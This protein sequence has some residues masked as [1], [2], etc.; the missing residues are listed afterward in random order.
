[1]R[2]VLAFLAVVTVLACL[3]LLAFAQEP[4]P[5][6]QAP[7]E[8]PVPPPPPPPPKP[9]QP[10]KPDEPKEP[11][12]SPPDQEKINEAVKKGVN[13]LAKLQQKDG[14]FKVYYGTSY[15][16][17]CS[18]LALL[19][20]LKSGVNPGS[21]AI[22][23]GFDYLEDLPL[24]RMY[25]VAIYVLALEAL[26]A[27]SEKQLDRKGKPYIT[28]LRENIRRRAP[29]EDKSKV[30]KC[31]EWII[32]NQQQNIWR[33]PSGGEDLSNTQY[34]LLALYSGMRMGC[35][36][37][38]KV[39]R[40][41]GNYMIVN[42]DKEGEEVKP[43]P[44]P[45]ADFSIKEL[46]KLEKEIRESLKKDEAEARKK[47][48]KPEKSGPSTTV[49]EDPYSRFGVE[50]GGH[51]MFARGWT[52]T[53]PQ[54]PKEGQKPY[55]M[56]CTGS[57]TTAGLAC[58]VIVKTGLEG[59][60]YYPKEYR[61]LL[62]KSIRDGAAWI[63]RYFTVTKNPSSRS[64]SGST[65]YLYYYLYGLERAGILTLCTRFGEHDWYNKGA[66]YILEQQQKEGYWEGYKI[67]TPKPQPGQPAQPPRPPNH[68]DTCFALLFL[69]KA[70]VPVVSIPEE[71]YTGQDLFG[72]KKKKD[73]A[74]KPEKEGGQKKEEGIPPAQPPEKKVP[75]PEPKPQEPAGKGEAGK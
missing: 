27:P 30:S 69:K 7:P 29:V 23:K 21:P 43:F 60:K 37:D 6:S 1:M 75:P 67:P 38:P 4:E 64:T 50:R 54:P 58:G 46:R 26:Y 74:Q 57:M 55:P 49:V 45:A 16:M 47:G 10:A 25:S 70:T 39:F 19:A 9:A 51:K 15:P 59:S 28:V 71:I 11:D 31:V 65:T 12:N 63:F 61:K 72:D 3:S 24:S 36:I 20:L 13:W 5:P 32:S 33:Y 53:A 35:R 73:A 44:V 48:Q 66:K 8:Q 56:Y 42:Q 34:A 14:S 17:G 2:R 22:R 18:A 62:D 52:Y 41:A 40:K 68:V